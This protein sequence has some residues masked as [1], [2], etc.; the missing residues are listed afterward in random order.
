MALVHVAFKVLATG[1]KFLDVASQL[2]VEM[3]GMENFSFVS[4][5]FVKTHGANQTLLRTFVFGTNK[6]K[7]GGRMF[8]AR[9][10][11][12][13]ALGLGGSLCLVRLN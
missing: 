3:L 7:G 11:H 10:I 5:M 4:M 1:Q 13:G 2:L 12:L 9:S 6:R 8:R